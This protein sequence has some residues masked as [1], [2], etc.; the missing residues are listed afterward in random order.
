M[1]NG[2]SNQVINGDSTLVFSSTELYQEQMSN[3]QL[4]TFD[5]RAE[6]FL[7]HHESESGKNHVVDITNDITCSN[8][9]VVVQVNDNN[10]NTCDSI[11]NE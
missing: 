5:S 8:V 4:H 1:A 3:N 6:D 11:I 9:Q 10:N 2:F 7:S